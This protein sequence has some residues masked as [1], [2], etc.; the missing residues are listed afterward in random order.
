MDQDEDKE[1]Q[2][3]QGRGT[4]RWT[5]TRCIVIRHRVSP[6]GFQVFALFDVSPENFGPTPGEEPSLVQK[7]VPAGVN[8]AA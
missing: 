3:E 2:L 7:P 8:P 6:D 5:Q 4:F 1:I